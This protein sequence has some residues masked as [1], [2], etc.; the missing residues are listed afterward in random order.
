M[1]SRDWKVKDWLSKSNVKEASKTEWSFWLFCT[2][3]E[4]FAHISYPLGRIPVPCR[5]FGMLSGNAAKMDGY[6]ARAKEL[7]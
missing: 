1:G 5:D 6:I 2:R 7:L 4:N 3:V